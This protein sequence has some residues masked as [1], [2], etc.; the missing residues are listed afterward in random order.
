MGFVREK[1]THTLREGE[2]ERNMQHYEKED[3]TANRKEI[4]IIKGKSQLQ[5]IESIEKLRIYIELQNQ[6]YIIS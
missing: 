1:E 6:K 4:K 5:L 2:E 3:M